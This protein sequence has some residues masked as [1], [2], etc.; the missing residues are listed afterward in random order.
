MADENELEINPPPGLSTPKETPWVQ[1]E[2]LNKNLLA[3]VQLMQQ[4]AVGGIQGFTPGGAIQAIAPTITVLPQSFGPTGSSTQMINVMLENTAGALGA[5]GVIPFKKTVPAETQDELERNVLRDSIVDSVLM[6]FP[7]GCHNLV[8]VNLRYIPEK[9]KSIDV[10]PSV[11]DSF[12]A[13][14]DVAA[15]FHPNTPVK[16]PGNLRVEW[17]NYDTLNSHEVVVIASLRPTNL[18]GG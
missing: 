6:L 18:L 9:G 15:L 14:D 13:L 12:I 5:G 7:A 3:L 10:C 17:W 8:E 1:L 11:E 2:N 16:A 4:G